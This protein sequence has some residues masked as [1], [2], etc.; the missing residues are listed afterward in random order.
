MKICWDNLE[1]L[2]YIGNGRWRKKGHS[3][4]YEESC[5]NCGEPF[6]AVNSSKGKF[7]CLVCSNSGEN[8]PQYGIRH[9]DEYK[10]QMSEKLSGEN[11]PWFGKKHTKE[12]IEK[13][14]DGGYNS[15]DIPKYNT[16]APQ[17]EWCEKVR[18]SPTDGNILEVKC[19][20][21]NEWFIPSLSD[22]WSRIKSINS[23]MNGEA[24]LYCSDQCKKTCSIYH[25]KPSELMK[26]DAIR[27]GRL[28]WLKLDREVQPELRKMVLERDGYQCVKCDSTNKIHCHHI[29]PVS[30]NPLESADVDN[31]MTLCIDCH[32]EAH[33][34]EGCKL[35]QLRMEIC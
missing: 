13:M 23:K 32:R 9:T 35:G 34:K 7:C 33:K 20:K 14:S 28:N 16:Y 3:Y 18:R 2:R 6:L 24:H 1:G 10:Q 31:C 11:H 17:I 27:A 19:T 15:N 8:N 25:K 4:I 12:S 5:K 26:E 21:C 22:V 30:T 29:Y